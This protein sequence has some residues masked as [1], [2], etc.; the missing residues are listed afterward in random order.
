MTWKSPPTTLKGARRAAEVSPTTSEVSPSTKELAPIERKHPESQ[1][2]HADSSIVQRGAI[3]G[4]ARMRAGGRRR[5]EFR[6]SVRSHERMWIDNEPGGAEDC[7]SAC[8][9]LPPVRPSVAFLLAAASVTTWAGAAG[10]FCRTT[11]VHEDIGYDPA[12]LGCWPAG[13]PLAWDGDT[14]VYSLSSSASTQVSLDDF[15]R[16]ADQALDHASYQANRQWKRV[17]GS[18]HQ[19]T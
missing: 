13:K 17:A 7:P 19:S 3:D 15:A 16:I 1:I 4:H 10:A 9:I 8:A 6:A 12:K 5:R 18:K 14:V 11:T 2:E